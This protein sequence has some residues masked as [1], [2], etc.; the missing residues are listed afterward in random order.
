MLPVGLCLAPLVFSRVTKTL[1]S[2]LHA[3]RIRSIW[4]LDD[5]LIIDLSEEEYAAF[6]DVALQMLRRV[7]VV[8]GLAKSTLTPVVS[9]RFPGLLLNAVERVVSIDE[10][11]RLIL[12]SRAS[13]AMASRL[14][15][16]DLPVLHGRLAS[17]IPAIPL[18]RL[19]SRFLRQDFRAVYRSEKDSHLPA[20]LSGESRCN[21]QLIA[22]LSPPQCRAPLLSLLLEDCHLEVSTDA[23]DVGWE[24]CCRGSL[25]Q[26]L[27]SAAAD[28]PAHIAAKGLV[29]LHIFLRDFPPP[30][31]SPRYLAWRTDSSTA[32]ACVRMAVGTVSHPLLLLTCGVLLLAHRKLLHFLQI[33][34]PS[35]E[36]LRADRAPRFETLP[37]WH[38]HPSVFGLI[39]GWWSSSHRS[40]RDGVIGSSSTPLLVEVRASRGRFRRARAGLGVS[41]CV[42]VSS[43][44]SSSRHSQDRRFRRRLPS[45]VSILACPDVVPSA[46]GSTRGRSV[47]PTGSA[48]CGGSRFRRSSS[49]PPPSSRLEEFRRWH[50]LSLSDDAFRLVCDS[51]RASSSARYDAV[52]RAF[53]ASLGARGVPLVSVDIALI[54]DYLSS[55]FASGRAYRT[56]TLHRAVLS[57]MFPPFD[58]HVGGMH[59]LLS[60]VISGVFQRRPPSR[61]LFPS[62]NVSSAF[63]VLSSLASP[64]CFCDA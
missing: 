56:I 63:A 64:L 8:V 43:S 32:L 14:S 42:R 24:I 31:A 4:C 49:P 3:R 18:V 2:F 23:S 41:G 55:L 61:R 6:V 58:G 37:D 21:L 19:H 53:R 35:E 12:R 40:L 44:S 27:W 20:S 57:S 52:W 39:V 1:K 36:T 25:L 30:S 33:F 11:E 51:W 22:S 47:S 62:W 59:P 26:G 38:L 17:V 29:A 60:R 15:C 54:A 9:F 45:S 48:R 34:G 28:A 46:S 13:S 5:F 16:H 10:D 7:G 50:G